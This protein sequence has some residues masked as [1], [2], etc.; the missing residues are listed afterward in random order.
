MKINASRHT[1]ATISSY[2]C[3]RVRNKIKKCHGARIAFVSP[4][5]MMRED[6]HDGINVFIP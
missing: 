2:A 4:L 3:V 6:M 5:L 1:T